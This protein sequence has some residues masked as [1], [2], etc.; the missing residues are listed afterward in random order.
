MWLDLARTVLTVDVLV[1]FV[2]SKTIEGVLRSIYIMAVTAPAIILFGLA[3]KFT[4]FK[5]RTLIRGFDSVT[6][7]AYVSATPKKKLAH[8]R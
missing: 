6:L 3:A 8:G 4:W 5:R 2:L 1:A 7:N